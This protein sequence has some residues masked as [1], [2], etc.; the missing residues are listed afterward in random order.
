MSAAPRPLDLTRV[1]LA[2]LTL[3]VLIAGTGWVLRPF[4]L[5]FT[6]ATMIAISTWPILLFFQRRLGG[7][8]GPAVAVM[9]TLLLLLLV[10]PL[11]LAVT[12]IAENAD[13]IAEAVREATTMTLPS[14]PA[15]LGRLP[16]VGAR[17]EAAWLEL[18]ERGPGALGAALAPYGRQAVGL[19][20]G[21]AAS[22][23]GTLLQFLLTVLISGILFAG[24][25]AAATGVLRFF[26]RLAG[27]RGESAAVLAGKAIRAVALGVVVTA[28]V[29]STLAGLG[30]AVAGVP[31]AGLLTALAL[32]LCIA[33][34]GPILVLLPAVIWLYAQGSHGWATALLVWSV[35]V[36]TIDNFLRPVLIR[37][38]ADLPLLL[39]FT[40]VIGGLI[41][42]GV[43]GL[44]IGP[45]ILAVAYTLTASWIDDMDRSPA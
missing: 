1:L 30:L 6:W 13:R 24:G 8:R 32:V 43:V 5:A 31:H 29:Q 23:G 36:G 28:L 42:F 21:Q 7:R 2:V 40:G 4:L 22:F 12:T 26:R 16:L 38:G 27:E 37:R 44:F 11:A 3:G 25:E 18:A 19:L 10:V 20:A 34:V 45:A 15:W 9:V 41:A 39:I 14:P 17:A 35:G 33:Q